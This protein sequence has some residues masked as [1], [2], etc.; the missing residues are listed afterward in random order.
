MK[1]ETQLATPYEEMHRSFVL[2]L[3]GLGDVHYPPQ[4]LRA[5]L[6]RF[7]R[8]RSPIRNVELLEARS[9]S[10]LRI[11]IRLERN[12]S[13]EAEDEV[14]QTD[15]TI[16]FLFC[17]NHKR[18]GQELYDLCEGEEGF[19]QGKHALIHFGCSPDS[20]SGDL[21]RNAFVIKVS[22]YDIFCS[23]GPFEMA[24]FLEG[25]DRFEDRFALVYSGIIEAYAKNKALASWQIDARAFSFLCEKVIGEKL[26]QKTGQQF[27][28]K[29]SFIGNGGAIVSFTL[30]HY[31]WSLRSEEERP[32][33][34]YGLTLRIH[35]FAGEPL[36][37]LGLSH[38]GPSMTLLSSDGPISKEDYETLFFQKL[39]LS[40]TGFAWAK[41]IKNPLEDEFAF[42]RRPLWIFSPWEKEKI[43]MRLDLSPRERCGR[44]VDE[45]E[46]IFA[47]FIYQ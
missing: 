30:P 22:P 31:P 26:E 20:Y 3:C 9:S 36:A 27:L 17:D 34:I 21:A 8:I 5:F 25:G 44:L 40:K 38:F 29:T 37:H 46:E 23:I 10:S 35:F 39:D 11:G 18:V 24:S 4:E 13:P 12:G 16:E 6:R 33:T 45:I 7:L 41:E 15:W 32:T 19:G 47:S 14:I 42:S 43:E 2:R 1:P 28:V